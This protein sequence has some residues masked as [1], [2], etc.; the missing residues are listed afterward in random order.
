MVVR[1]LD[2]VV[3]DRDLHIT[4]L[5]NLGQ[6]PYEMKNLAAEKSRSRKRDEMGAIVQ[7][8]MKRARDRI[9]RRD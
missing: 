5:Y 2:K 4:H 8:W 9:L 1:G 6:D 7:D 3:A